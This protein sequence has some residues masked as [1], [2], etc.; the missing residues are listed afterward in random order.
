MAE[1]DEEPISREDVDLILQTLMRLGATMEEIR[2]YLMEDDDGE[3]EEE[4]G[5]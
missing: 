5:A 1:D 3:N 2:D 4:S